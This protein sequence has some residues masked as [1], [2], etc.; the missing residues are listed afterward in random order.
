V[1]DVYVVADCGWEREHII[2]NP[3]RWLDS[4]VVTN[5]N[6]GSK[7]NGVVETIYHGSEA[8]VW[9]PCDGDVAVDC[10]A[11]CNVNRLGDGMYVFLKV[12]NISMTIDGLQIGD[13]F[14]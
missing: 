2:R 11:G 8:Y 4:C 1:L 9:I 7:S 13:I 6:V 14:L 3:E 5:F 12:E 10:S